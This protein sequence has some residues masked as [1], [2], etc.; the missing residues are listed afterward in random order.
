ME[1][2]EYTQP[3]VAKRKGMDDT[4]I[5]IFETDWDGVTIEEQDSLGKDEV[6][7][8]KAMENRWNFGWWI[9]YIREGGAWRTLEKFASVRNK[10]EAIICA[11][12]LS[13]KAKRI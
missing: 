9:C 6:F 11:E 7:I 4:D 12:A 10:E 5:T 3:E 2:Q 13:K 8:C 1:K